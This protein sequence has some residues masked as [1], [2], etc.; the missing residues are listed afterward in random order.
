MLKYPSFFVLY[1]WQ[2]SEDKLKYLLDQR[3]QKNALREL[4]LSNS[5]VDFC[6]ND[7]LGFSKKTWNIKASSGS[8]GSRLISGNTSLHQEVE[9]E[10]A[11]F[12]LSPAALTYNSGYDA[13]LGFFSCVPQKEDTVIYDQ[14]CHASIR[15]G[16]RLG[17]ARNYSFQH[18]NISDLKSKI[19]NASGDVFVVIESIYSMDGDEAHLKEISA[20]CQEHEAKLI[21]D[22]AH[23]GGVFGETGQGLTKDIEAYARIYTFGKAFG[24]HGAAIVGS[25]ILKDYLINFSRPLIYST[26]L[27]PHSI[28]CIREAYALMPSCLERKQLHQNIKLFTENCQHTGLINSKSAIQCILTGGNNETKEAALSLQKN[29]FDIRPILHPT[30]AE[31]TER[32]RICLHAFNTKEEILNLCQLLNQ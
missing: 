15:D 31:G 12:H 30:V 9:K 24:C 16:I 26:A 25:K 19:D 28:L 18:N 11:K 17:T 1:L 2:M 8:T 22:E 6:S 5:L 29:G 13:N 23:A 32:I 7:Y 14:L 10:I 21:I 20:L 3:V 27:S 4:K